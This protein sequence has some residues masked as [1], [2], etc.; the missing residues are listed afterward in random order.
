LHIKAAGRHAN[1]IGKRFGTLT[2]KVPIENEFL[3]VECTTFRKETYEDGSRNPMVEFVEDITHDLSRRD[4]TINAMAI[5]PRGYLIDP[6][7]GKDDLM[8]GMLRA[9]GNPTI[10]FKED[11]LRLL[12]LCR[13]AAQMGEMRVDPVTAKSARTRAHRILMVSKERWVQEMDKLLVSDNPRDGLIMME[14]N[15]LLRY[16]FPELQI[17]VGYDQRSPYHDFELWEHTM[18]VV[19]ALPK[20]ATLRWAGLFHDIGKPFVAVEK[21][22]AFER[23]RG[24]E[25]WMVGQVNYPKHDMFGAEIVLKICTYLKFSNE[26][27]K[28]VVELVRDH[29]LDDSPLKVADC[30][31]QKKV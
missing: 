31:S 4:F 13:F 12:R 3:L 26:R 29:S 2:F 21:G 10:R 22:K 15:N 20:D 16:M 17:Q 24:Y 25:K 27:R 6:F 1:P 11:P 30:G 28:S 19:E 14:R 8:N 23:T 18:K 7:G 9:V 5:S